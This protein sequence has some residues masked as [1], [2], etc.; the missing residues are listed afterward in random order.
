MRRLFSALI[1]AVM[2]ISMVPV[3][4]VYGQ[5]P[6]VLDSPRV[7]LVEQSTGRVLYARYEHERMYT[8]NLSKML[9]A[10]V[11]LDYL[12]LDDIVTVGAEINNMPAGYATGLH[13]VGDVITVRM[14]LKAML[15]HSGNESARILAINVIRRREGRRNIHYDDGTRRAFSIL[16][17]EKARSIGAVNSNFNNPYGRRHE[18]HFSTAYDMSVITRAFMEIPVLAEIAGTRYYTGYS[19]E[20]ILYLDGNER[21]HTWVNTNLMLPGSTHGHPYVIGAKAG[22]N[23]QAGY[24]LAAVAYYNDLGLVAIV[25]GGTQPE[26]WQDTRRLLDYGFRNYRFREIAQV[27]QLIGTVRI[28]NP[29][30]GDVDTLDIISGQSHTSLLSHLEYSYVRRVITFDPLLLVEEAFPAAD[31]SVMLRAPIEYGTI[32]GNVEYFT[33]ERLLFS[34]PVISGRNVYEHTFDSDM[35]YYI[36]MIINNIFTRNALPYW[37]GF[38]GVVFG[39]LCLI[40]AISVVRRNRRHD[41]QKPRNRYDRR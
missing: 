4:P 16:L 28:E 38:F 12:E 23:P 33:G 27:G 1:A 32:V 5:S 29:R 14:L 9:T 34:A 22:S 41:R 6:L 25:M 20:G 18:H 30:R 17:N 31:G 40:I 24:S 36:A 2:F 7:I 37:I 8:A 10:M 19:L 21:Q 11:V 39:I 26:R 3:V 35:D 13:S 15:M